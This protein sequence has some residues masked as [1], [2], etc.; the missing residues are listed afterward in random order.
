MANKNLFK[1]LVGMLV[2]RADVI[3]EEGAPAYAFSPKHALAQYAATGCLH[4]TFYASDEAQLAKVLALSTE[5]EPELIAKTAVYCREKS[6]MKDMPALLC[7]VLSVRSPALLAKVFDRVIDNGKMLRT[8][9]Q[10]MRSGVVGRKSLGTRP[11]A[12]VRGWLETHDDESLF[13]ASVGRSP[14]LADV[15]KMVHP[16][17]QSS[18]RTALY[19][20]L[21]GRAHDESALPEL[22][23]RFESYK[24]DKSSEV[25]PVPFEM[26]TALELGTA[27]WV[28]VATRATW[29]QTR[30]NLNAFARHGVF[31]TDGMA[32][33][34]AARLADPKAIAKAR[35]F[36]YQLMIAYR[37]CVAEVPAVVRDALQDAMEAATQNVPSIDGKVYVLP[38]VSSSMSSPITGHRRGATSQVRCVDVAALFAASVLRRN[39]RA[40]V[41]PFD[42]VARDLHINARDSVMTNAEKLSN[43]GGGGT[44]VSAP[45]ALLNSKKA[46]GDLVIYVSDNQ[47]WVDAA[48]G[49]GGT[50]TMNEWSSFKSRNPRAKLV[51]IDLQ[52]YAHTQAKDRAD[53]LN[54]G[55]FSDQ[56]F[57]VIA[58]FARNGA[59]P[60]HWVDVIERVHL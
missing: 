15:I 13:R 53:I 47:S 32:E 11:K 40:E 43:L 26:L 9:V 23:R 18:S 21:I 8:F 3:N 36:P 39:P 24:A 30:M 28:A 46:K 55:G 37:S 52:P 51:C 4:S 57:E 34:V 29:Q 60:S 1:S 22:V 12:L 58:E 42:H 49:H 5:V 45:L 10:I 44:N 7:A 17:P 33:L 38:D 54:I 50:A 35:V 16:K 20:Y 25:P 31:G 48:H 2:P 41:I 59:D 19:G 56:V 14:T 6:F 27:E